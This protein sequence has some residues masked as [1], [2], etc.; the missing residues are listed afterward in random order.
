MRLVN[1][2]LPEFKGSTGISIPFELQRR[3]DPS[4]AFLVG[5]N[6]SGKSRVLEALGH[7]FSHLAS[8]V[9]PGFRFEVEY[10][11]RH[12]RVLLTTESSNL[13]QLLGRSPPERLQEV[14]AWLLHSRLPFDGWT[15]EHALGAW[16]TY[17]DDVL[18]FRVIGL[19]S[20]PA[21]RLDWALRESVASSLSQR[22]FGAAAEAEDELDVKDRTEYVRG[23]DEIVSSQLQSL[24]AEPR[25]LPISGPELVLPIL[26]LMSHPLA[27][28]E[29]S[30]MRDEILSKA[31]LF[32]GGSLKAVSFDVPADWAALL[33]PQRHQAFQSFLER[34][35]RRVPI[36]PDGRRHPDLEPDVR[37]VFVIDPRFES[38]IAEAA[39]SPFV[40]LT[41]LQSWAKAGGLREPRLTLTASGR[42]GLFRD[43][44][45]SD[46]EFLIVGRYSLLFL[47][48]QHHDCL[49][50][51][52]EP[53]THFNDRW[54]I[55]LVYDLERIL[56]GN[57]AQ[58]LIATHSDLTLTD[59]DRSDVFVM[60]GESEGDRDEVP[61]LP[62]ISPL[63]ADRNEISRHIFGAQS[64][65]G[66]RAREIVEE[67]LES[68]DPKQ[69]E[70]AID[71]VG[72]GHQEFR[73]RYQAERLKDDAP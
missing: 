71:R 2:R 5:P 65:S 31:G 3:S 27:G 18:P 59:A 26:A 24:A 8:R 32:A 52:D 51:F 42:D 17:L 13:E 46:G 45:L 12:S 66:R 58:V 47:L 61:Q 4:L 33:P 72:P 30:A 9:A 44:D 55:D 28:R 34:S 54:K 40:W 70:E 6:G 63:G 37:C 41:Q 14:G 25:S 57:S 20:G 35:V 69:L 7:I 62:L 15:T 16:P 22:A 19:S 1:L 21:S 73:L 39:S 60:Q 49:V 50:L 48:E 67:A 68:R 10:E 64:A 56:R 23:E 36:L 38:W 29:R 43:R 11:L 53:E